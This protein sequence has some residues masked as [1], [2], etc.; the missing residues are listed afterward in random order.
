MT[1][2]WLIPQIDYLL[3]LQNF[4]EAT[5]GIFDGFFMG[6]TG[7][8]EI[9]IPIII[10]AGI[11]WSIS[12]KFGMYIMWNWS[13]G[14]ILCQFFKVLAC[15]YRPWVLDERIH[16]VPD[17]MK[18]AGGYSFP[19]GHTQTAVSVWGGIAFWLKNKI[20]TVFAVLLIILVAFSRNYLGVHTPQDVIV[21]MFVGIILLFLVKKLMDWEE[22]GENRDIVI[23]LSVIL[24]SVL[25]CVFEHFKSYPMDYINGQLLVN[26]VEMRI[27]TF[28]KVGLFLGIFSGWFLNKRFVKFDGA[29]GSNNEKIIRFLIGAVILSVL[30][31][32][33]QAGLQYVMA[34]NY[35]MFASSFSL[36]LFVTVVYPAIIVFMNKIKKP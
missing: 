32:K 23:L 30:S 18:M 28:P 4:R 12:S 5:N 9:S 36:S 11:Y 2:P 17:A 8:G 15:I 20:F 14:M 34:K 16:P 7:F 33:M 25:L 6:I 31:H 35:A 21:S 24:F 10:I 13:I 27:Y 19:S 3:F 26:P 29:I 22:K 1:H